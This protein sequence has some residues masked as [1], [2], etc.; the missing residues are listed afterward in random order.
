MN[1]RRD[2]LSEG[3]VVPI[4]WCD[5]TKWLLERVDSFPKSQRFIFG[6]RVADR[7]VNALE[8]LVDAAY[9]S[10]KAPLGSQRTKEYWA[11]E[12]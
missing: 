4:K 2:E 11:G 3:P 5:W 6:Q 7:A 10:H 9:R 8:I 12:A 1:R